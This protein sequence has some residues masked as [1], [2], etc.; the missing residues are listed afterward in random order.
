M[1]R[2]DTPM[3][4]NHALDH[5]DI[6]VLVAL[7]KNGRSTIQDLA[8]TVTLSSR[9]CLERVRRLEKAGIISGYQAVIELSRLSRPITIFAT[10]ALEKQSNQTRFEKRLA[11]AEEVI[12]CWEVTGD[13]DYLARV[14]CPDLVAYEAFTNSLI[15]DPGLGVA[16]VVS[17]IALRPVVR[18][19]GYPASLLVRK[20][21]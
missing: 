16:R 18:F 2:S 7:Q 12:E 11:A 17:H 14:V 9:A 10:I 19:A 21:M 13:V 15:D 3:T 20:P 1:K 8:E 4:T 5:I 6:K